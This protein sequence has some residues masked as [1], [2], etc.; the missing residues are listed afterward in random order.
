VLTGSLKVVVSDED[1]REVILSILGQGELFGEMAIFG[2][3]PRSASVVAVTPADLVMI[4]KQDFRQIMKD[5]FEVA[6]RIM[7]NLAERLRHADRKIESLA[8]MDVYGRVARLL[9]EMAEERDGQ[10]IV[11]RKIS[12]Q[13]IAKMIGASREM[14]S[15]VMKD[16]SVQGLIEEGER[17]IVLRERLNDL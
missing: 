4:A 16:L 13:D 11:V 3:Q 17:G 15:R 10:M 12:K 1:G 2:E 5:N 6:W 14:V 9:L 7:C 8:L